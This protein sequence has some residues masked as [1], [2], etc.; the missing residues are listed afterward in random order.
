MV[1]RVVMRRHR[2]KGYNPCVH[3][4]F[5][6]AGFRPGSR[7]PFVSAKVC[8]TIP[9]P[10]LRPLHSA[11][12]TIVHFN[13]VRVPSVLARAGHAQ[14]L[15]GRAC[16]RVAHVARLGLATLRCSATETADSRYAAIPVSGSTPAARSAA[17]RLQVAL[18]A[19]AKSKSRKP[20]F[21]GP[22]RTIRS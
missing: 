13:V 4:I 16:V 19:K 7:D 15:A 22:H 1:K 20:R 10:G 3:M 9:V 18:K 11:T 5:C 17:R 21:A 8:K 12:R 2:S 6:G 14:Q